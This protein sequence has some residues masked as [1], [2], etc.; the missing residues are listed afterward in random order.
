MSPS[1][2]VIEAVLAK[3]LKDSVACFEAKAEAA[4]RR[5]ER[6][7]RGGVRDARGSEAEEKAETADVS[8]T[9]APNWDTCVVCLEP[10]SGGGKKEL[11]QLLQAPSDANVADTWVQLVNCRHCFHTACIADAVRASLKAD[12]TLRHAACPVCRASVVFDFQA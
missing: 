1:Q 3:H 4:R 7:G 2:D 11:K 8:E 9:S 10:T 12:R 5:A 6:R